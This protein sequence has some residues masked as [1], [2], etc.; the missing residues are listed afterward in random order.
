[1][2][3]EVAGAIAC[4]GMFG[5]GHFALRGLL[6]GGVGACAGGSSGR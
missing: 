2:T 6:A 3:V 5:A 4:L 1:M